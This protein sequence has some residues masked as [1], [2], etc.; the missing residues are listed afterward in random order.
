[1]FGV[2]TELRHC[3]IEFIDD[4]EDAV[5]D[6]VINTIDL[7]SMGRSTGMASASRRPSPN[8]IRVLVTAFYN[9]TTR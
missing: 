5:L 2:E 4:D 7:T 6:A 8:T 9:T 1:M 3:N